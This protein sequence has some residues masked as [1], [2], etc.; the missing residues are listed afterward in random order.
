MTGGNTGTGHLWLLNRV[1]QYKCIRNK[2]QKNIKEYETLH[3]ELDKNNNTIPLGDFFDK[4]YKEQDSN[5]N[6]SDGD[7]DINALLATGKFEEV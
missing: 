6:E 1:Q 7:V 2:L 3:F 5:D 4:E